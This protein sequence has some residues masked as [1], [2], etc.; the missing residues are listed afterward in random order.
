MATFDRSCVRPEWNIR[1]R[2]RRKATLRSWCA[3]ILSQV[4]SFDMSFACLCKEIGYLFNCWLLQ[5]HRKDGCVIIGSASYCLLVQYHTV[6]LV[7][8]ASDCWNKLKSD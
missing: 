4:E 6:Y 3:V 1:A 5:E 7:T 8:A 2:S